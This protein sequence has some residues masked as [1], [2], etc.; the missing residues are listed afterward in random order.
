MSDHDFGGGVR[1][2]GPT[3]DSALTAVA[4]GQDPLQ[5]LLEDVGGLVEAPLV[6]LQR[7]PALMRPAVVE[8]TAL[9]GGEQIRDHPLDVAV[10][11]LVALVAAQRGPLVVAVSRESNAAV[12]VLRDAAPRLLPDQ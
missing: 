6:E 1:L 7:D 3:L 5:S 2:G 12:E 4:D 11:D 8:S 10:C 9:G